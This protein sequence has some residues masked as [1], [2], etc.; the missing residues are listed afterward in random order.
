MLRSCRNRCDNEP[1]RT[2]LSPQARGSAGGRRRHDAA[3][4]EDHDKPYVCDSKYHACF[5]P[6]PAPSTPFA[7]LP[8]C[9]P[10]ASDSLAPPLGPAP[11]PTCL[12]LS[13]VTTAAATRP[14]RYLCMRDEQAKEMLAPSLWQCL[15]GGFLL[16]FS[17]SFSSPHSL[18]FLKI[19]PLSLFQ[20]LTNK[21]I[22]QNPP[23]KGLGSSG[24]SC[25]PL[26]SFSVSCP[27]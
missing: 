14:P 3:S 16:A 6:A 4:Q 26:I 17:L 2:P 1:P 8:G 5:L 19:H 13:R 11:H 10:P 22:T 15:L 27:R 9:P 20:R 23:T 18:G 7:V 12:P 24:F 21:S 25:F